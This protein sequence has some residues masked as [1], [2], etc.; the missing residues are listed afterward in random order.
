MLDNQLCL[1]GDYKKNLVVIFEIV[2]NLVG[3]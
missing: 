2:L 1:I 3:D